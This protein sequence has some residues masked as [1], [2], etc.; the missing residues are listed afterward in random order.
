[1]KLSPITAYRNA[2]GLTLEQF[3][4]RI[5]VNKTTVMRWEEGRVPAERVL[6]IE[7]ATGIPRHELRPD[8]FEDERGKTIAE[9]GR[10]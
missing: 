7:R 4:A 9:S 6:D 8:L 5:P 10:S 3:A 1:M 2:K